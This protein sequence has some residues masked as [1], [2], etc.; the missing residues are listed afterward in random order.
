MILLNDLS[1]KA[2]KLTEDEKIEIG[3]ELIRGET[4]GQESCPI[5]KSTHKVFGD[6]I[7]IRMA[8]GTGMRFSVDGS[9]FIGFLEKYSKR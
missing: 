4:R 5:K 6:I 1:N 3:T 9:K 8:D 7:E 2:D